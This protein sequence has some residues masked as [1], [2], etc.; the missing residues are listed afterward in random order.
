MNTPADTTSGSAHKRSS[1]R[2]STK[3]IVLIGMFCAVLTAIS[4][5]SLPMPTGVPITIQ[6]FGV[7]L[8]GAVLGWKRAVYTTVVYILLGAVGL[9]VFSNFRGGLSVLT[10]VTGGYILA[11]PL[12]AALCGVNIPSYRFKPGVAFMIS[13]ALAVISVLIDDAAG[14]LQWAMLSGEQTFGMI[15]AYSFI[16]FIPKDIA[17]AVLAMVIGKQIRKV[18]VRGGYL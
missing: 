9:P 16:A 15:M 7:A 2:I 11:W 5:I 3:D 17:L 12:M 13:I 8:V 4:Q 1:A 18:L 6:L 10:N 14:G